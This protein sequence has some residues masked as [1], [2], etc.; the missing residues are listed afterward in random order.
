MVERS[1][2]SSDDLFFFFLVCSDHC[3]YWC[4]SSVSRFHETWRFKSF[5][6]YALFWE[7]R[8]RNWDQF[9]SHIHSS[10]RIWSFLGKLVVYFTKLCFIPSLFCYRCFIFC[11][12]R[13]G[14]SVFRWE[15]PF[16]FTITREWLFSANFSSDRCT[17]NPMIGLSL[18]IPIVS[19]FFFPFIPCLPFIKYEYMPWFGICTKRNI[20]TFVFFS[21][22]LFVIWK[23]SWYN[24]KQF[25]VV[26]STNYK[27]WL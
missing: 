22:G 19:I 6:V 7:S 9:C 16:L 24:W 17:S 13:L 10:F 18:K 26:V 4:M 8:S 20:D 2:G 15:V 27:S 14:F 3:R 23:V 1:H 11:D 12:Y 5:S 21:Y 25:F